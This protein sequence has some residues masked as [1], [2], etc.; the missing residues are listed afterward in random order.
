MLAD[1]WD[2]GLAVVYSTGRPERCRRDTQ[3][4][5]ERYELPSAPL[6]MRGNSDRRPG[7]VTKLAVARRL[8]EAAEVAYL[9][10]D[11]PVVVQAL[12]EDG[13]DV[14]HATW[15]GTVDAPEAHVGEAQ[16]VLFDLQEGGEF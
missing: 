5:L 4:W 1:A 8:R 11:D 6:H 15:M 2:S 7:R 14:V 10:D 3:R 13:F 16:Q 9:V 12:R